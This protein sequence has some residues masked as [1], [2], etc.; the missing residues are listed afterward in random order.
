MAIVKFDDGSEL[1]LTEEEFILYLK[2]TG[3][4]V[5]P[6]SQAEMVV[7]AMAKLRNGEGVQPGDN[8][9]VQAKQPEPPQETPAPKRL[10]AERAA[11]A[12]AQA[13]AQQTSGKPSPAA[14]P[15][16]IGAAPAATD[17]DRP[18]TV[19]RIPV[20]EKEFMIIRVLKE[21]H[22]MG[23]VVGGK[24]I[25]TKQVAQVLDISE[26]SVSGFLSGLFQNQRGV[27]KSIK[28]TW[29]LA[30]WALRADWDVMAYPNNHWPPKE[31]IPTS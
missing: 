16:R 20:T 19:L 29:V 11:Q 2:A 21:Y 30:P 15:R 6:K 31:G 4:F 25:T 8:S 27:I 13:Q 24:G 23:K 28:N 9:V 10:D 12:A 7:E 22:R 5:A 3:K 18:K 1:D 26:M 14:M 17:L